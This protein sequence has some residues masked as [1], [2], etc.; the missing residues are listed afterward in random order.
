MSNFHLI[1]LRIFLA[2]TRPVTNRFR[3]SSSGA[4]S[5]NVT[6]DSLIKEILLHI[7]LANITE[8]ASTGLIFKIFFYYQLFHGGHCVCLV[9]AS[10]FSTEA[11]IFFTQSA[12]QIK[13]R[14]NEIN[15]NIDGSYVD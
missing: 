5:F 10:A 4:S 9:S 1:R 11:Q 3:V 6:F 8:D 14:K 15:N 2:T 13:V 7:T 12:R